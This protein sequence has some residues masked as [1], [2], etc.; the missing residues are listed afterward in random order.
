MK[1]KINLKKRGIIIIIDQLRVKL[2]HLSIR[3]IA[4]FFLSFELGKINQKLLK[5]AWFLFYR[6]VFAAVN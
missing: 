2:H 3:V 1:N 4:F 5:M 6:T